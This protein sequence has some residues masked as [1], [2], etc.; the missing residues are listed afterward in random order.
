ME[1]AHQGHIDAHAVELVSDVRDRCCSLR[2]VDG[3]ADQFGPRHRQFLDLDRGADHID[4]VRVGHRLHP[5]RCGA[6]NGDHARSPADL[7]LAC[8]LG[9]GTSRLDEIVEACGGSLW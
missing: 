8:P 2:R 5:H 9:S 1:V 6:A 4:G 7:G 3:D